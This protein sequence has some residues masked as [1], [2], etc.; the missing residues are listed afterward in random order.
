MRREQLRTMPAWVS[1][2]AKDYKTRMR[3]LSRSR[4]FRAQFR[5]LTRQP[6][7]V[8]ERQLAELG[9]N[10]Q[11]STRAKTERLFRAIIRTTVAAEV[12]WVPE[13]D[14]AEGV[15]VPEEEEL[16]R[17][18]SDHER[19]YKTDAEP[20]G[21]DRQ[22]TWPSDRG[23]PTIS[24]LPTGATGLHLPPLF[25]MASSLYEAAHTH[26]ASHSALFGPILCQNRISRVKKMKI[27]FIYMGGIFHLVKR[28]QSH[29]F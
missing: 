23:L 17:E 16:R 28:V 3:E 10:T 2:E 29:D 20:T 21:R 5:D 4:E 9:L 14:E 8:T 7:E 27:I 12:P 11:G 18:Q 15:V 22:V 26:Q 25:T 1:N 6:L 13:T 19:A 24:E